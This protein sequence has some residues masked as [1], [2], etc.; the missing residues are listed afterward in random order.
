[1]NVSE[2]TEE[3]ERKI[4]AKLSELPKRSGLPAIVSGMLSVET[5]VI[6]LAA[7]INKSPIILSDVRR[8]VPFHISTTGIKT[9]LR[10]GVEVGILKPEIYVSNH[11]GAATEKQAW[12][13]TIEKGN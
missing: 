8:A 13:V 2:K 4:S 11:G 12:R 10:H 5:H 6:A 7:Q 1:M 9:A 3:L